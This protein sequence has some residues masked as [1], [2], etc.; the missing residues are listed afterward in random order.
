M[1]KP[2]KKAIVDNGKT[3]I[4]QL[5]IDKF[6]ADVFEGYRKEHA[7]RKLSVI[8]VEDKVAILR[9]IGAAEV[10]QFSMMMA[11]D[12][13]GL[14]KASRYLLEELW[15]DGDDELKE[16]EDYFIS[17]MMQIQKALNLKKSSFYTL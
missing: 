5:L 16:D 2:E 13:I 4:E 12:S 1:K 11:D 9:P 15:I 6:G 14:E 3:E 10:S 7:P 8:V 17:A